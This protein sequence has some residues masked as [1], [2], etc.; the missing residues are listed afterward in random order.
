MVPSQLSNELHPFGPRRIQGLFGTRTPKEARMFPTRRLLSL[1]LLSGAL[2]WSQAKPSHPA[3]KAEVD[4]FGGYVFGSGN[5]NQLGGGVLAGMDLDRISKRIGL[6]VEF[7]RTSA[8][9]PPSPVNAT[10][11]INVL[12]GPRFSLRLSSSSRVVP[13]VDALIGSET[14]HNAG[15]AY[16]WQF[17]NHTSFAWAFDGGLDIP[18]SKHFGVRGQGGYLGTSLAGSTYGGPAGSTFAGRARVAGTVVFRF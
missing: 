7:D 12:A 10:S 15:Q 2:A 11:E 16:T 3:P 6:T 18:L 5:S 4:V 14:F 1:F 9:S 13:F 8:S 17:N